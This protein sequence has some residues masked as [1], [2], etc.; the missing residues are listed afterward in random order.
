MTQPGAAKRAPP[1]DSPGPVQ[2]H[3]RAP[4]RLSAG[5]LTAWAAALALVVLATWN[6]VHKSMWMDE[7]YT[8]FTTRLPFHPML[9]RALHYELQPPLYFAV[10][11]L[12]RRISRTVEFGRGL[13]TIAAALVVVTMAGIG[14]RA[15]VRHWGLLALAAAV[16]P[17]I[18]WAAAE[19]RGYALVVLLVALTLYFFVRL[20]D[21]PAT[22]AGS[23]APAAGRVAV[24]DAVGYVVAS[25]A[26]LYAFYYGGFVLLGEWL[27][28]LVLRRRVLVLT[29]LLALTGCALLPL[30]PEVLRQVAMHPV[31]VPAVDVAGHPRY[32]VWSTVGTIVSA[33]GADATALTWPHAELVIVL[34]A[35]LIPVARTLAPG[36]PWTRAE[37]ALT[38][39]G[40]VPLGVLGTLRLLD[41]TPVQPRHVLVTVP[42]VL[43]LY[44]YWIERIRPRAVR[45]GLAGAVGAAVAVTLVTFEAHGLQREDWRSAAEYVA[46][47]AQPGDVIFVYDPD[48][49]LPFTDYLTPRA[50]GLAVFGMPVDMNYA[51]YD[52]AA[53]GIPDTAT[54]AA[55]VRTVG[56]AGHPV[57]FVTSTRLLQRL[58][59]SPAVVDR[60]L[61]AHY[62]LDPVVR[63]AGIRIVHGEP[64]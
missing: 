59:R 53:Y 21:P 61:Q 2:V 62:S 30:I 35:L 20:V 28:A 48:R 9:D 8:E 17:G 36:T 49:T 22:V 56:A 40:A 18:V 39:V 3:G 14:R 46:A 42:P 26:L 54:V 16:L 24:A 11:D 64:R 51:A 41:V 55:R 32:A 44:A 33:F 43:L 29:G 58:A 13:S 10:L 19:L 50:R 6:S 23:P 47:R 38:I 1:F 31:D 4:L 63:F 52:P 12:W 45:V 57:W 37:V 34:I 25:A 60:W 7:A 15:G 5:W 27:A